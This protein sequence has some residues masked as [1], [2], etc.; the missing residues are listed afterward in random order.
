ME[1][2]NSLYNTLV[3][4][5]ST[6]TNQMRNETDEKLNRKLEKE[7]VVINNLIKCLNKYAIY[8]SKQTV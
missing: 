2:A 3:A 8:K 1:S 5:Q 6:I 4:E 7:L